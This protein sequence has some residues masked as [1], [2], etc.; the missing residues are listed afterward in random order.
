MRKYTRVFIRLLQR[1][2]AKT[3]RFVG[4]EIG[5]WLGK[6]AAGLLSHFPEM[7]LYLVDPWSVEPEY[8]AGLS[9]P[10]RTQADADAMMRAATARTDFAGGRRA[11]LRRDSLTAS[12]QFGDGE[13]HFVIIDACDMYEA[14]AKDLRAWWPKVGPGGVVCGHDYGSSGEQTLGWGVKRAVDEFAAEGG[15]RMEVDQVSTIW[16]IWK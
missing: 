12:Q 9:R 3:E 13:L 2:W 15:L 4:A 10:P 7:R 6:N 5:V 11:I 14:V 16:W 8:L 1:R